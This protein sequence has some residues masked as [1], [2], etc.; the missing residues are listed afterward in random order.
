MSIL[1]LVQSKGLHITFVLVNKYKIKT[2]FSQLSH[3]K[4]KIK[5][6]NILDAEI[7]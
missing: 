5:K 7:E 3:N 1:R 6:L 2:D 4:C